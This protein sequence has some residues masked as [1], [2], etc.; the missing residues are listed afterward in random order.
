MKALE[1]PNVG[2]KQAISKK[3]ARFENSGDEDRPDIYVYT[4]DLE[5]CGYMADRVCVG[6]YIRRLGNPE[7][8]VL[9]EMDVKNKLLIFRYVRSEDDIVIDGNEYEVCCSKFGNTY[10]YELDWYLSP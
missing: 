3:R 9:P 7:K 4:P 8:I 5:A 2:I 6:V 1:F 10:D